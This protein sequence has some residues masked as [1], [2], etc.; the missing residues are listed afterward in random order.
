[1]PH[2]TYSRAVILDVSRRLSTAEALV[3]SHVKSSAFCGGKIGTVA[4][5]F[6]ILHIPFHQFSNYLLLHA[7]ISSGDLI[8]GQLV[9]KV[10]SLPTARD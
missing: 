8:V 10:P 6:L 2:A 1:M 5:L 9:A 7:H 3:R 4:G